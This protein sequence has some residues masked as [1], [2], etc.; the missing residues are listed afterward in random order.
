MHDH[1]SR[2]LVPP[3]PARHLRLPG[4]RNLRDVGG[5]PTADGRRTRWR[6]LFR[7]DALDRLPA[8]SQSA[9]IDLGL[10]LV[11]DL[12]WPSE[13]E[14]APSVFA[15]SGPLTYLALSLL[16]DPPSP[17]STVPASYLRTLDTRGPQLA[18]VVH[19]VAAEDGLPAL[20]GCAGGI[21]RTGVTIALLL[22]LVGVPTELIAEDYAQ[23]ASHYLDDT[24]DSGLDDWRAGA[25]SVDARPEY[26]A[27]ALAHLE[28]AHGGAQAY[29]LRHGVRREELE[30][31][32]L[33]LTEP[34]A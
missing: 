10:R 13:T 18:E 6:T 20:I 26:M 16:E 33:A 8:A 27:G 3:V 9:L 28:R 7:S 34:A 2:T 29:L 11:V 23:S 30:R 14:R 15:T 17:P 5:Y 31:L 1:G 22:S 21:D 32:R 24:F 4:T 19:R 12:R 25:V